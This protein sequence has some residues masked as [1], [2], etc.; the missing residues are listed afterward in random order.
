MVD[1]SVWIQAQY[2]DGQRERD[3][4][5]ILT[6]GDNLATTGIVVAELLQGAKSAADYEEWNDKLLAPRFYEVSR[7]TWETVG[8]IAYELRR[9][10]Q[11]MGL[12]DL[13]VAVVALENDLELYANDTDFDRVPGL[14]RYVP[15]A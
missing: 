14:R 10:G 7:E 8:S 15:S 6:E 1:T 13:L 9:K 5:A 12:S 4:L 11:Q 2:P 3:E